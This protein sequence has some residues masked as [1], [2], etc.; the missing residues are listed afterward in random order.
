MLKIKDNIELEE[1][2]KFGFH[3]GHNGF[4][5]NNEKY[6]VYDSDNIHINT[7]TK[8]IIIGDN[9]WFDFKDYYRWHGIEALYDLIKADMVEK[10]WK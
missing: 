2:E 10:V 6:G 9:L 8:K 4:H 7:E 3:K 1:L 5:K